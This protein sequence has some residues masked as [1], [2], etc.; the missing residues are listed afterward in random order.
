MSTTR[1]ATTCG[2]DA[3]FAFPALARAH[4][5][6]RAHVSTTRQL[7][8]P[9]LH[10][11]RQAT[12]LPPPAHIA[13]GN[14]PPCTHNFKHLGFPPH[15]HKAAGRARVSQPGGAISGGA[16]AAS[17]GGSRSSDS[18]CAKKHTRRLQPGPSPAL[19][20][21][22]RKRAR[23]ATLACAVLQE[24]GGEREVRDRRFRWVLWDA[25]GVRDRKFRWML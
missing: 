10:T 5:L 15:A 16:R 9:V 14:S 13:P 1:H 18:R 24:E 8:R 6:A 11:Q 17:A 25:E 12:T 21:A 2:S 3:Q 19:E 20:H 4:I 22:V 23:V 7:A